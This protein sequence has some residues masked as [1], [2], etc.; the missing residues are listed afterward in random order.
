MDELREIAA[1]RDVLAACE[2]I[3]L[4]LLFGSFAEGRE[5]AQSDIDV[6]I[7]AS[8]PLTASRRMDLLDALAEATG[9]TVDLVDLRVAGPLLLTQALTKGVVLTRRRPAT[10]AQ[11]MIKMWDL[12][13]DYMPLVRRI[14]ATR[15]E[16]FLH[17]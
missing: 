17:G 11:L 10:L 9:R 12:N 13:A 5:T 6:G 8:R 3:E 4:G 1:V 14:Q 16:R 7:A 15:R 2:D